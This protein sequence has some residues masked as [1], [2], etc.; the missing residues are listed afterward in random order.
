VHQ[1]AIA[2]HGVDA[3]IVEFEMDT[4][5]VRVRSSDS[6]GLAYGEQ[7]ENQ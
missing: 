1:L 3:E 4:E 2:M 5:M 6:E 7:G